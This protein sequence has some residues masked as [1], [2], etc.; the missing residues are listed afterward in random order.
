M[1]KAKDAEPAML[2]KLQIDLSPPANGI[3][4]N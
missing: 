1:Q 2:E 3:R 4:M